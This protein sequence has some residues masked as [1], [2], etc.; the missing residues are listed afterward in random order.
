MLRIGT[1]VRAQSVDEAYQL[2]QSRKGSKVIGGGMWMR[3]SDRTIPVAIDL[4]DCALDAIEETDDAFVV[5][6]YASL[7]SLERH[8]G[9]AALTGGAL[10]HA[11]RDIV[12]PQMRERATV[13]GSLYGRFGFSDV[14]CVLL[15]L[16]CDVELAGAGR[17]PLA[18]FA[19]SPYE[20]D[21]VVRLIIRKHG[22]RASYACLRK[23]ATDFPTLNVCAAHWAGSWHLAVGA[24]PCR[25]LAIPGDEAGLVSERPGDSELAALAEALKGLPFGSNMWGSARFRRHLAGVL[26]VRAVCCAAGIP[27]PVEFSSDPE[28]SA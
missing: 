7:R 21:I 13:G 19:A 2:L 8:E 18:D 22:Y 20:R 6:A 24:R 9:L 12:G 3:L 16:D 11:L 1:L 26:G 10:A 25:A 5:G 4:S 17:I 15:A 14:L 23:A 27:V 28:V